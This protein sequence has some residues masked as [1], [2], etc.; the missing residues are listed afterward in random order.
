MKGGEKNMP[1]CPVCNIDVEDSKKHAME[2]AE[3]GDQAHK[4]AVE[5]M[6]EPEEQN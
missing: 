2:M 5:K 3:N 6:K 4:E 1:T